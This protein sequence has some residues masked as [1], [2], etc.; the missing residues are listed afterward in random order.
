MFETRPVVDEVGIAIIFRG[1]AF[2]VE[3]DVCFVLGASG[4]FQ[5]DEE[6]SRIEM[7]TQLMRRPAQRTLRSP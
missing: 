4:V 2:N 3:D 6:F 5:S 7:D 1:V